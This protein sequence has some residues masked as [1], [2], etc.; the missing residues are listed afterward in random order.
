MITIKLVA[1]QTVRD[2]CVHW[3]P[4]SFRVKY[5]RLHLTTFS[6]FTAHDR[7]W[8]ARSSSPHRRHGS[9]GVGMVGVKQTSVMPG[10]IDIDQL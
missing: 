10:R 5:R 3:H 8:S 7:A 4:V 2:G 6:R 9:C 1:N